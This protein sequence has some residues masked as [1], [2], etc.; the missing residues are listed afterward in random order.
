MRLCPPILLIIFNRPEETQKV[1]D[2]IK[3][4]KPRQLFVAADG[5]R[6]G[7]S[8]DEINCKK[9]R[10]IINQIDWQCELKTLFRE[11]NLGCGLA[12]SQAITWFFQ[13]VEQGIILE[14]DCVP[15]QSFFEYC[16]YCLETYKDDK[17]LMHINGTNYIADQDKIHSSLYFSRFLD[18]WG[19]ATWADRWAKFEFEIGDY[20]PKIIKKI[21]QNFSDTGI[22]TY[23]NEILSKT[24]NP[25]IWDYQWQ[26]LIILND[27]LIISPKYNYIKNIGF[28][29][30]ATHTDTFH[31]I[32]SNLKIDENSFLPPSSKVEI[33]ENKT[34]TRLAFKGIG[35]YTPSFLFRLLRKVK[36]IFGK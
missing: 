28:G 34:L 15:S 32:F 11:E 4:A 8:A 30:N 24:G 16:N 33:A 18:G 6:K 35:V 7:R 1:F 23:L 26:L 13:N 2:E 3:K 9:A 20:K 10:E 21:N 22:K 31:P 25:D 36:R 17:Q 27:G 19:W 12:P 29:S 5:V 14:D